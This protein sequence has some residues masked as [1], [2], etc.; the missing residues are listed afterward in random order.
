MYKAPKS[1]FASTSQI[2]STEYFSGRQFYL[3]TLSQSVSLVSP[4]AAS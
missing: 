3:Q 2:D 1:I 4:L